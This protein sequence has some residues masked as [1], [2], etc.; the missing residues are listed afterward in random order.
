MGGGVEVG[1]GLLQRVRR[2][3]DSGR[4]FAHRV[5]FRAPCRS[6]AGLQMRQS[7]GV[8][9]LTRLALRLAQ[10]R[11]AHLHESLL[12]EPRAFVRE[13]APVAVDCDS[14]RIRPSG[15]GVRDTQVA[16]VRSVHV[17]GGGVATRPLPIGGGAQAERLAD[18]VAGVVGGASRFGALPAGADAL[19]AHFGVRLETAASENDGARAD[20]MRPVPVARLDADDRAGFVRQQTNHGGFVKDWDGGAA[21]G[22]GEH[23]NQSG[24]GFARA[25][26][27]AVGYDGRRAR[28]AARRGWQLPEDALP[29]HPLNRRARLGDYGLYQALVGVP[30]RDGGEVVSEIARRV[31]LHADA[32]GFAIRQIGQER[33]EVVHAI[34]DEPKSAAGVRAV[35]APLGRGRFLEDEDGHAFIPRGERGAKRGVPAADYEDVAV[36]GCHAIPPRRFSMSSK[37]DMPRS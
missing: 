30:P 13:P 26:P 28:L 10:N 32:R 8:E 23:P 27:D 5:R 12:G 37:T 33:A 9:Y 29:K 34:V 7:A 19:G 14:E 16:G 36:R 15:H 6:V 11:A 31:R 3:A 21:A 20:F 22:V 35:A 18:S 25:Q 17:D 2:N 24:P 4:E 1:D